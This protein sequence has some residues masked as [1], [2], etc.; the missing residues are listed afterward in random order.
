MYNVNNNCATGSTALYM[1]YQFI[2]GGLNECVVALG[3]EKMEKGSLGAKY[4]DRTNP[5]DKHVE[6][7]IDTH[8]IAKAPFAPQMFGNAGRY[9]DTYHFAL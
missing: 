6:V 1:A 3:F 5:L 8:G 2:A 4:E 7:M 9:I